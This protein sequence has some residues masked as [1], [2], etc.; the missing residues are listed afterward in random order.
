MLQFIKGFVAEERGED[1]TEYGLLL[2][3]IAAIALAVII[4]DPIGLRTAIE[5]AYNSAVTALT[6]TP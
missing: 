4:G 6:T 3:F 2:A 1:L 5:D